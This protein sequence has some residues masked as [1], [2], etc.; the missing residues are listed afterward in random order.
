[1]EISMDK[2]LLNIV[3]T[4]LVLCLVAFMFT[5]HAPA[6]VETVLR[7]IVAAALLTMFLLILRRPKS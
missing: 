6:W 4:V 2:K 3:I 7:C 5:S 1:M